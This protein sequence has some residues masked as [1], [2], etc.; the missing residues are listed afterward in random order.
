MV[1]V[2]HLTMD[3]NESNKEALQA[4]FAK[5]CSDLEENTRGSRTSLRVSKTK[6]D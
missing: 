4:A 2:C 1:D 5:F 6:T 3:S